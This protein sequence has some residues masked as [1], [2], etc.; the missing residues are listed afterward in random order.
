MK[1]EAAIGLTGA[2]CC[3]LLFGATG[4]GSLGRGAKDRTFQLKVLS[5]GSIIFRGRKVPRS[6]LVRKLQAAGVK[7]DSRIEI[8]IA[9]STPA[10]AMSAISGT[11]L[12][13]GYQR[14]MFVRPRRADAY[15]GDP[16]SD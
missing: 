9:D 13:Q 6:R 15:S 7:L 4:C 14:I 11:L 10:A 1:R 8:S 2:L 5:D 12:T 16:G 3:M